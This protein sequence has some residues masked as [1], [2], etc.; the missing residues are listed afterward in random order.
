MPP[1][2][3]FDI[4]NPIASC[5]PAGKTGGKQEKNRHNNRRITGAVPVKWLRI[6]G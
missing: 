4:V 6:G 1:R 3:L 2:R 5:K